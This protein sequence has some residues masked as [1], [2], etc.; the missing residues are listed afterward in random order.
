MRIRDNRA[1]DEPHI[2]LVPLIDDHF[3]AL[4]G[5]YDALASP[6]SRVA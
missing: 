3:T 2:D 1:Q 4:F 5:H 6:L